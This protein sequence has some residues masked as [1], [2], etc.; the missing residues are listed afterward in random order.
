MYE[1][2][3]IFLIFVIVLVGAYYTTKYVGNMQIKSSTSNMQI[4]GVIYVGPQ[5]TLQLVKIGNE[6]IL[7]GVT[8]DNITFIKDFSKDMLDGFNSFDIKDTNFKKTFENLVKRR[9]NDKINKYG[10]G[11]DE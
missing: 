8:K 4:I 3:V 5:K 9:N 11:N 6:I 1:F 10:E 2:I 7:I